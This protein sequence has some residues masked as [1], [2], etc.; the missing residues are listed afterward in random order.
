[1]YQFP[2]LATQATPPR[3]YCIDVTCKF[4]IPTS[5]RILR[6]AKPKI[7]AIGHALIRTYTTP[8]CVQNNQVRH[9]KFDANCPNCAHTTATSF[10][11]FID[12]V[13]YSARAMCAHWQP[14]YVTQPSKYNFTPTKVVGKTMHLK[15][16]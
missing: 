15:D 9:N 10:L 8:S 6:K 4:P 11:R 14:R 16:W 1:M 3:S 12:L 2:V 5:C 7:S 13:L